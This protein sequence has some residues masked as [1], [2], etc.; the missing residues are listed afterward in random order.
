MFKMRS[1]ATFGLALGVITQAAQAQE[2]VAPKYNEPTRGFFVEHAMVAPVGQASVELYNGDD[3][4]GSGG[5]IRLGVPKAEVIISNDVLVPDTNEVLVKWAMND[6]A[7]SAKESTQ[8][9]KWSLLGGLGHQDVDTGLLEGKQTNLKLGVIASTDID[10]VTFSIAPK[11][12]FADGDIRDDTFLNIDVGAYIG[13]VDTQAGLFSFGFESI[14]ST[15]DDVDNLFFLG[16]RWAYNNHL[17]ID[18][19]PFAFGGS[20][21]IGVPGLVRI[22]A[23]F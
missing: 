9:I 2:P 6:F 22:N 8:S 16:G 4:F 20:D 14:V 3:V 12:V 23:A 1:L 13:I 19:V 15:E 5:S 10:A 18:V 17:N 21:L 7:V 11:F